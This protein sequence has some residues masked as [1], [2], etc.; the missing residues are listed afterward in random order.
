MYD[1]FFDDPYLIW[2]HRICICKVIK[3]EETAIPLCNFTA[4]ITEDITKTNGV[5][6]QRSIAIVGEDENGYPLKKIIIPLEKFD[7]MD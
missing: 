7:R 3:N 4:R 5:E 1:E 2:N 6:T